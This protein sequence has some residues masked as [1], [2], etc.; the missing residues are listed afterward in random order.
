MRC[1]RACSPAERPRGEILTL[2]PL[3]KKCQTSSPASTHPLTFLIIPTCSRTQGWAD[4]DYWGDWTR[5]MRLGQLQGLAV[6]PHALVDRG[7]A[8][9]TA[10]TPAEWGMLGC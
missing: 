10:T 9:A 4:L 6:P 8:T 5:E 2:G 7:T 1:N 3:E